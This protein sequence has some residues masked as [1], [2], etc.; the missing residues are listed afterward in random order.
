MRSRCSAVSAVDVAGADAAA[1]A[2]DD[3]EE[4]D[5]DAPVAVQ[6]WRGCSPYIAWY[7]LLPPPTLVGNKRIEANKRIEE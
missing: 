3:D 4:D 5:D 7:A 2:H 1:D 6:L